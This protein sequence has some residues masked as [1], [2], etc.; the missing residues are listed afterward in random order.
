MVGSIEL[1]G[2]CLRPV[3]VLL[4]VKFFKG[5]VQDPNTFFQIPFMNAI[6]REISRQY[7]QEAK[8]SQLA[9]FRWEH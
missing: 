4:Q 7:I 2:K 3:F 5:D 8:P 1:L 6:A 9:D